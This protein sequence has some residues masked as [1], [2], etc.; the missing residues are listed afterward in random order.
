MA[1]FKQDP[2][3]DAAIEKMLD[4]DTQG[5]WADDGKFR[6]YTPNPSFFAS[7]S[8]HSLATYFANHGG[9][10]FRLNLP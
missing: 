9:D 7:V 5:S 4:D 6:V 8:P 3:D 2:A 10:Q 1:T